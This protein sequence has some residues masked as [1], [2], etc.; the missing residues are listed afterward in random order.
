MALGAVVAAVGAGAA[1]FGQTAAAGGAAAAQT[2]G[3]LSLLPA[4]IEHNATPGPLGTY[5]VA[6]RSAAPLAVTV[7][8]RPWVQ[9]A[10]GK[11]SVNRRATLPGVTVSE[12]S[13]TLAAGAE[14]NVSLTLTAAPAAGAL[15]GGLEVVG[16]PADA[17]T[18]KGVVL[19]YRIIGTIRILPTTRSVS[20]VAGTPKATRGTAVL[21]VRNAGNTIDEVT[22]SV[23]LRGARGSRNR[24]IQAVRIL[25]GKQINVPLGSRLARGS[26]TAIVRLNQGGKRVL[27][28]TKRFRVR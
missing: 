3:G 25:P 24:S 14:R 4:L 21:P 26:Y 9:S 16:L 12:S 7:T 22:G 1:A 8:P 17:A 23:T 6:N 5:T 10:T 20:L 18:R 13:F 11:V 2:D 19:G 15:Y 28:V 27:T